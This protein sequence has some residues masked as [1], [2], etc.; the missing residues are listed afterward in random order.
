M[1]GEGSGPLFQM[2]ASPL[3][4]PHLS[5]PKTFAFIESLLRGWVKYRGGAAEALERMKF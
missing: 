4:K 2:G 1:V 5:P 3:P